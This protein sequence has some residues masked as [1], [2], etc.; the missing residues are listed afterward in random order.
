LIY[1]YAEKHDFIQGEI[2]AK[3][4]WLAKFATGKSR[5]P[6]HIIDQKQEALRKLE[7]IAEDYRKAIER[8]SA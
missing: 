6:D 2:Y 8:K 3:R 7:A 4:D 1:T 5:W